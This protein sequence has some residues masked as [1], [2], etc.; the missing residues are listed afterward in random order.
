MLQ[1]NKIPCR[2][3]AGKIIIEAARLI[4]HDGILL[5]IKKEISND[6]APTSPEDFMEIAK[7]KKSLTKIAYTLPKFAV[8]K[9]VGLTIIGAT[10]VKK[11]FGKKFCQNY[12][13]T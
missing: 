11:F 8:I 10:S 6:H 5:H 13:V 7:A 1:K 2:Q 4:E 12:F 3:S 9:K